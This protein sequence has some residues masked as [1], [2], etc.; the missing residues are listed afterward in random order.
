MLDN[1]AS[2]DHLI[3]S[4]R[5]FESKTPSEKVELVKSKNACFACLK[6]GHVANRCTRGFKCKEDGCCLP[7]H[8]LLH[9]AH[10]LGIVFH[11]YGSK[12]KTETILQLQR[13]NCSKGFGMKHPVNIMWDVGS[14]ISLIN[15]ETA[16]LLKLSG[17]RIKL[18]ITTVGGHTK[19]IDSYSYKIFLHDKKNRITP[20]EVFDIERI[21]TDISEARIENLNKFFKKVPL[22]EIDRPKQGKID[23]L[24]VFQYA[25]FHPIRDQA[26]GHFLHLKNQFEY[27][28][29]GSHLQLKET[30]KKLVKD[31]KVYHAFHKIENFYSIEG[32]GIECKP[33]C[34]GCKKKHDIERRERIPSYQRKYEIYTRRKGMGSRLYVDKRPKRSTR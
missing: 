19:T 12:S 27:V 10:K 14:T 11:N 26:V 33:K 3:S 1:Q 23:C 32:L 13:I 9:E 28:I 20:I 25:A 2:D 21:S 29:G 6:V 30:T 24:I 7:H 34:G 8:Q 4:C 5:V 15:F 17:K 16:E 31:P 22:S 18:E